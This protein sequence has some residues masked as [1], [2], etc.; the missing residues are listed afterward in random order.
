MHASRTLVPGGGGGLHVRDNITRQGNPYE[1][2]EKQQAANDPTQP[3]EGELPSEESSPKEK[4]KTPAS[5]DP[6]RQGGRWLNEA[7]LDKRGGDNGA[8][9]LL[10]DRISYPSEY[11]T[12]KQVIGMMEVVPS[13]LDMHVI[14]GGATNLLVLTASDATRS[15]PMA[16]DC[17]SKIAFLS[18]IQAQSIASKGHQK[19]PHRRRILSDSDEQEHNRVHREKVVAAGSLVEGEPVDRSSDTGPEKATVE[20]E[21]GIE[22]KHVSHA[23][24]PL[25]P[26][27]ANGKQRRIL[28]HYNEPLMRL[29]IG[30]TSR[31][32]STS[33]SVEGLT[34]SFSSKEEIAPHCSPPELTTIPCGSTQKLPDGSTVDC[35]F[36][37]SPAS[38][39]STTSLGD[40]IPGRTVKY[41]QQQVSFHAGISDDFIDQNSPTGRAASHGSP[42]K[43]VSAAET[44]RTATKNPPITDK[45]RLHGDWIRP[46]KTRH[47]LHPKSSRPPAI[48]GAGRQEATPDCSK[49]Q[50]IPTVPNAPP[51]PKVP[52]QAALPAP[53]GIV[54]AQDSAKGDIHIDP[55]SDSH[56]LCAPPKNRGRHDSGL[57]QSEQPRS[58]SSASSSGDN[59]K[60]NRFAHFRTELSHRLVSGERPV[61]LFLRPNESLA[62]TRIEGVGRLLV[63]LR[64]EAGA[65][66][67]VVDAVVH[68][69][70]AYFGQAAIQASLNKGR[71]LEPAAPRY[72]INL[73]QRSIY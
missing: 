22:R 10:R 56:R 70:A 12:E 19:S 9:L 59:R 20:E 14:D 46:R 11:P 68:D 52:E 41:V 58:P 24:L 32:T 44:S 62:V 69:S 61:L 23:T 49:I 34:P 39:S 54:Y 72:L 63:T 33:L 55:D 5:E 51:N 50:L 29:D 15:Q 17:T 4:R 60:D 71:P 3:A 6:T 53:F 26:Y 47:G 73:E 25:S 43:A 65:A 8:K 45:P 35:P 42:R 66:L 36:N 7:S 40:S 30:K 1:L 67:V 48:L 64:E 13:A 38:S 27:H 16:S 18:K 37:C 28:E 21:C 57:E 2:P 31:N